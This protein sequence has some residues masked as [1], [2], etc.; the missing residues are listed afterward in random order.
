LFFREGA[1]LLKELGPFPKKN[2]LFHGELFLFHGELGWD[3]HLVFF[4][5]SGSYFLKITNF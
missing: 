5:S 2:S 3:Y 1:L 4:Y